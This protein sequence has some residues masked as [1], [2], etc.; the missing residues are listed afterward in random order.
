MA[1][2]LTRAAQMPEFVEDIQL[3]K[4]L[5]RGAQCVV[6]LGERRL[7]RFAVKILNQVDLSRDSESVQRF[8]REAGILARCSH[9][10]LAKILK[11][12]DFN[13]PSGCMYIIME[14]IDGDPLSSMLENGPMPEIQVLTFALQVA[15][16]LRE[17]HR[18]GMI[19]RD[20]KPKN[21]VVGKD[22]IPKII[23]FGLASGQQ[24]ESGEI[25]GTM[26]YSSPEQ[27]GLLK[28]KPDHRSDLYSLGIVLFECLQGHPPYQSSNPG[29]LM[30]MHL[31]HEIP[32]LNLINPSLSAATAELV[33]RLMAKDPD[34][35]YLNTSSLIHDL[36]W[37]VSMGNNIHQAD[38]SRLAKQDL[39]F[40]EAE[41]LPIVGRESEISN[42]KER[43][44]LAR[45]GVGQIILI[46]GESGSGKT[47]L[48]RELVT[49]SS[50]AGPVTV[51][52][53]K[54]SMS[55]SLPFGPIREALHEYLRRLALLD[56]EARLL[57]EARIHAA[58][59]D[60]MGLLVNFSA[61]LAK[62]L[63]GVSKMSTVNFDQEKFYETLADFIL[64]LGSS[65]E[66]LILLF[67]DVQWLDDSSIRVLR[68]LAIKSDKSRV[69]ILLSAR[70]EH[71]GSDSICTLLTENAAERFSDIL[72]K[73]LD[74]FS[75]R[76]LISQCLGETE[77]DE[78]LLKNVFTRSNGNAFAV[79]QFMGAMIDAG[80][81]L[82]D[83]GT[84]KLNT[85]GLEKLKLPPDVIQLL[86][87][88]TNNLSENT[89]LFLK[90]AAVLSEEFDAEI[91]AIVTKNSITA[92]EHAL[93]SALEL[94]LVEVEADK[95]MSFVHDKVREAFAS[96]WS[97]DQR[98]AAHQSIADLLYDRTSQS[99]LDI[100]T[101]ANHYR[102]GLYSV[103]P[104]RTF[105][106]GFMA[107]QLASQNFAY[108]E[109]LDYFAMSDEVAKLRPDLRSADFQEAFGICF[110][111][112][113]KFLEAENQLT[114]AI[115]LSKLPLQRARVHCKMIK[116]TN[117]KGAK[118]L[119]WDHANAGFAEL[120]VSPAVKGPRILF[121]C[122]I[123]F[124]LS[125][126]IDRFIGILP[127]IKDSDKRDRLRVLAELSDVTA[128]HAY[129][130]LKAEMM[131]LAAIRSA[132]WARR[133]GMSRELSVTYCHFAMFASLFRLRKRTARYAEKAMS[134]ANSLFDPSLISY[135]Q[136]F[137]GNSWLFIADDE[138]FV[139]K[140]YRKVF[141]YA[142][143]WGEP[144]RYISATGGLLQ[145]FIRR[146]KAKDAFDL[147]QLAL[148]KVNSPESTME[149]LSY[150]L[151]ALSMCGRIREA[152]DLY[153]EIEEYKST[154]ASLAFKALHTFNE[155]I[156]L[157]EQQD[158]GD[159][160]DEFLEEYEKSGFRYK[161]GTGT[162]SVY[163]PALHIRLN[164]W[165]LATPETRSHRFEQL[166]FALKNIRKYGGLGLLR[167]EPE[168]LIQAHIVFAEGVIASELG[169]LDRSHLLL[170]RAESL[171][172][173]TDCP[174]IL[175]EVF[176][177]R[178]LLFKAQGY[179]APASQFFSSALNIALAQGWEGRAHRLQREHEFGKL[180]SSSSTMVSGLSSTQ[181]VS[182]DGKYLMLQ[183]QLNTLLKMGV[184]ASKVSGLI[185][186]C[187]IVLNEII[188]LLSPER[189]FLFLFDQDTG[190][191][192]LEIGQ[193]SAG[194]E[195][196]QLSQYS[197]TIVD[198]VRASGKV[199]IVTGSDQGG[200]LSTESIVAF[201]LRSI[202]AAPLLVDGRMIGVIYLDSRVAKGIFKESDTEVL[203][204]FGN[205]IAV[206]I[207]TARATQLELKKNTLQK[208]LELAGA[209]QTLLLPK[210]NSTFFR[211]LEAKAFFQ[212]AE[213]AGGDWWCF[214]SLENGK[215]R[216]LLGDVTGHGAGPA[217]LTAVV[218]SC[219]QTAKE[220][221][222][223]V[224]IPQLAELL[225][226]TLM[227]FCDGQYWM[228]F[229][230]IEIDPEAGK[231]EWW[232]MGSPPL[233][234]SDSNSVQL[235]S[236]G[237]SMPLGSGE[238]VISHKVGDFKV[239]DQLMV[240]SDGIYEF[241][242]QSGRDFGLKQ[243]KKLYLE[244][245][246]L[247]S[248]DARVKFVADRISELRGSPLP[249][250]DI[251]FSIV[252]YQ[253]K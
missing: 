133:L 207:E 6:Y 248:L 80:I 202:L 67:D 36:K 180:L 176:K 187:R 31:S 143:K 21:I 95:K 33:A 197:S 212:T 25:V 72:L 93:V 203:S 81:L 7:E 216:I 211:G 35:R 66:L 233:L 108:Q 105:T 164:Q 177:H 15:S 52:S 154:R 78:T 146:G 107:A 150:R 184:E 100:F 178:G 38:P 183:K 106:I 85:E 246:P 121:Q 204:A 65:D 24:I 225:N 69:L 5:G 46:R 48:A 155:G 71:G 220:L 110:M 122:L 75:T 87:Q 179:P 60:R 131:I 101:I 63:S 119:A 210:L 230:A 243:L 124:L 26:L 141:E 132:F 28:R 253:R 116:L 151:G 215:F 82:A 145:R 42:L 86:L 137:V 174:W 37:L 58:I 14:V 84:W 165:I 70:E 49:E 97:V 77:V 13:G 83:W 228:T 206:A 208:D 209:V 23:D 104:E 148:Q 44:R 12:S 40:L 149:M 166:R 68:H 241:K 30:H 139:E 89:K 73:T 160:T 61:N 158:F 224:E 173:K 223:Q 96:L 142:F 1:S 18:F 245:S 198:K 135:A 192:T 213:Q 205:H 159:R 113:G 39:H 181:L 219:Y 45:S 201:D 98:A 16:A 244:S 153:R 126:F 238:L 90:N 242:D 59:G 99:D 129:Y 152:I 76:K 168:A 9:P 193:D 247:N 3:I 79:Q 94:K 226:K 20:I 118:Q 130:D 91:I 252:Q 47:R 188:G 125:E 140:N 102:Q 222:R 236:S 199:M 217:M 231:F 57:I 43:S 11:V 55:S 123:A 167:K 200:D 175:F 195:F 170:D 41:S 62:F 109:A 8:Y 161:G 92:V 218:G 27:T 237:T 240:F 156:F 53:A 51:L 17:V 138:L 169:E 239:E 103:N 214:D 134:V 54:S 249:P 88:R 229:S 4:E 56:D 186:R 147:I 128:S 251:T 115:E 250:D 189:A 162:R 117:A 120:G 227:H 127:P 112:L 50:K 74:I 32:K 114:L 234:K 190:E 191:A 34:D 111:T 157:L 221:L 2:P 144:S 185:P 171:A 29:E 194:N 19:H 182:D 64:C 22:G 172:I 196:T 136:I 163:V 232:N 10:N 235:I